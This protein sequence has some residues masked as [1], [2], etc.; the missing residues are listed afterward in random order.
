MVQSVNGERIVVKFVTAPTQTRQNL[1]RSSEFFDSVRCP[2]CIALSTENVS[3]AIA[4]VGIVFNVSGLCVN[5]P[6]IVPETCFVYSVSRKNLSPWGFLKLFSQRLRV[7]KQMFTCLSYVHIS[8]I[9]I[10]INPVSGINSPIY[11]V[12]HVSTHFLIHL[13]AHFCHHHH[14]HHPSLLHSFTPGSKPTFSIN[15]SHLNTSSTLDCLHNHGTGPVRT[16]ASRF[17]FISFFL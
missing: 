15:P 4:K 11:S 7:F 1:R 6:K 5:K 17:I 10:C 8:F 2:L 3:A 9:Q 16:Y 13:S 14:S 12:S